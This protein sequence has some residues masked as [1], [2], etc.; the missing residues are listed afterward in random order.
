MNAALNWSYF[1]QSLASRQINAEHRFFYTL[2][3]YRVR[4]ARQYF[5]EKEKSLFDTH[6]QRVSSLCQLKHLEYIRFSIELST[7]NVAGLDATV[8][9]HGSTRHRSLKGENHGSVGISLVVSN[10]VF[11]RWINFHSVRLHFDVSSCFLLALQESVPVLRV[12]VS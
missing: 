5:M 2:I 7:V 1:R 8:C 3:W 6:N 10:C 11:F 12:F 4:P 9:N